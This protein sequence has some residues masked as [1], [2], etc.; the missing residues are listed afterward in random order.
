MVLAELFT[1]IISIVVLS[2]AA[3]VVVD[4]ASRLARFFNVSTL[5]IGL[6]LM[7]VA[8]SLPELS[9]SVMSSVAGEGAI[10]AGNV[11]GSNIANVL[12]ILGLA[13]ALYG[14]K[15]RRDILPDIAI[16]LLA[17]TVISV[18]IIY[19]SSVDGG[20]LSFYEGVLLLLVFAWYANRI[21][22][23]KRIDEAPAASKMSLRDGLHAFLFF[24]AGVVVVIIS[25]SFVVDS[26]VSLAKIA[27]LAE[28]FIGATI[29]AI[30]T[31]LPELSV[32]LAAIRKKQYGLALGDAIG[33]NMANLTLVLGTAA[34]ISP[35]VVQLK[36]FSVALLFAII[37]NMAFFYIAVVKKE[38]GRKEGIA[39]LALYAIYIIAIFYLQFA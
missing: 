18:Y 12:L 38:F 39:M 3:S 37:A 28:S 5:A 31:S 15:V 8:T 22:S 11:F 21:L 33:S 17:T 13:A 16:V 14:F 34:I 6:L 10:A 32:D 25:S 24:G 1:L 19:K 2:R 9:V 7:S 35:I 29:I 23:K 36:V 4:N 26:A 30:G 20:A 27:G